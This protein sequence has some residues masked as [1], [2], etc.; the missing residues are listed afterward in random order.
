MRNRPSPLLVVGAVLVAVVFAGPLAYVVWRN[1]TTGADVLAELRAGQAMGSL[2][3]TL[4]LAVTVSATAAALGTALAWLTVRTD[5][6]G[7]RV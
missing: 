6:P 5:L 1:V 3:R 4:I 2:A 7:R